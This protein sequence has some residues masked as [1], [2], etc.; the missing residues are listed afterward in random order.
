MN[1]NSM[2]R[3]T[4]RAGALM[5]GAG[6]LGVLL[7]SSSGCNKGPKG[8]SIISGKVTYKNAPVTGGSVS[9]H[10]SGGAT[11][12]TSINPDGTYSIGCAPGQAKVT[13]ETESAKATSGEMS[14]EMENRMKGMPKDK[15]EEFKKAMEYQQKNSGGVGYVAIPKKYSNKDTTPLSYDIKDGNQTIDIELTD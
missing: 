1:L 3:F 7:L 8:K 2:K 15:Q 6:I 11:E 4:L 9:F 5:C 14:K 10:A 12:L 13:V